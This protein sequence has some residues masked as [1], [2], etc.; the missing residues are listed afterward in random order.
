[1]ALGSSMIEKDLIDYFCR[2]TNLVLLLDHGGRAGS[3]FFQCL[4]DNHQQVVTCPLVHYVYSYWERY[5]PGKNVITLP[6]ARHFISQQ[7]YFRFLYQDPVGDCGDIITKIGGDVNA[8]FDRARYRALIDERVAGKGNISRRDL[9]LYAYAAYA[10]CRGFD[11]AQASYI[12]LNDAV[13]QRGEDVLQGFSGHLI[14]LAHYDFPEMITLALLRDPRAQYAS[15]KHQMVNEL[16]NNYNLHKRMFLRVFRNLWCNQVTLD[17][18]PAHLCL[19]YQVAAYRC[20]LRKWSE[21]KKSW[22]FLRNEDFNTAFVSTM[23]AVCKVLRVAPDPEWIARGDD[24]KASM[25]GRPWAG[26]GAYSNR[27]QTVTDG[28][29]DNGVQQVVAVGPSRHVMER[30]KD[31]LPRHEQA[32]LEKCFAYEIAYCGY[33]FFISD[34]RKSGWHALVNNLC[35]WS[36][37]IPDWRWVGKAGTNDGRRDR[38]LYF[39]MVW[40]LYILARFKLMEYARRGFFDNGLKDVPELPEFI[41]ARIAP[42]RPALK[43]SEVIRYAAD[44]LSP[45]LFFQVILQRFSGNRVTIVVAQKSMNSP[46]QK[47]VSKWADVVQCPDDLGDYR[48]SQ[49]EHLFADRE[50][51]LLSLY[52]GYLKEPH[53]NPPTDRGGDVLQ[54]DWGSYFSRYVTDQF[55]MLLAAQLLIAHY[56]AHADSPVAA[57]YLTKTPQAE[58]FLQLCP[59]GLQVCQTIPVNLWAQDIKNLTRFLFCWC[60]AMLVR[61]VQESDVVRDKLCVQ[62]VSGTRGDAYAGDFDWL[63]DSK[64]DTK[65]VLYLIEGQDVPDEA[66]KEFCQQRNIDIIYVKKFRPSWSGADSRPVLL[67]ASHVIMQALCRGNIKYAAAYAYFVVFYLRW[68]QFFRQKGICCFINVADTNLDALPKTRALESVGGV[69][70]SFE[71]S[72]TGYHAF[73]DSRP[74]GRHQYICWGPLT[75]SMIQDVACKVPYRVLP[76]HIFLAGN[77]R[78]YM[79]E[80]YATETAL[81]LDKIRQYAGTKKI[82]IMDSASTHLKFLSVRAMQE[83]YDAVF[84]LIAQRPNDLFIFKPQRTLNLRDDQNDLLRLLEAENRIVI[85]PSNGMPHYLFAEVDIV[86]GTPIYASSLMEAQAFNRMIVC[87]DRSGWRHVMRDNLPVFCLANDAQSLID[88]VEHILSGNISTAERAEYEVL[89]YK[90]DPYQDQKGYLRFADLIGLWMAALVS[91]GSADKALPKVIDGY[92]RLW[93]IAKANHKKVAS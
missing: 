8:P 1:M 70:L 23:E 11:L 61:R 48:N 30:W 45:G 7:S 67:C 56:V 22:F 19:L 37:E 12:M 60:E 66:S 41:G 52:R 34:S 64:I 92:E 79:K 44:R 75:A 86:V 4:F 39:L 63:A 38:L 10:L 72:A 42:R 47:L 54:G 65:K 50:R 59:P 73:M 69:D 32:L 84:Q 29:L 58:F 40:P 15:T 24:Y 18:G 78:T 87:F 80:R 68:R 88:R 89:N 76:Q 81:I 57:L 51:I 74:L 85:A 26:T 49:G 83:F 16:G 25:M 93:P 82:L 55:G 90:I 62:H 33:D 43:R 3:N 31:R 27:Y 28:P 9:I 21:Y 36:G 13:S 20:L 77:M 14:D 53:D 46:M 2:N 71:F 17:D 91:E 6:E 35:P 5:F